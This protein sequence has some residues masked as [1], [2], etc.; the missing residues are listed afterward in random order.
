MSDGGESMSDEVSRRRQAEITALVFAMAFPSVLTWVYFVILAGQPAG[1]QQGTYSIGKAIQFG[2]P[3]AWALAFERW[4]PARTKKLSAGLLFG[5][6][7]GVLIAGT[8]LALFHGWLKPAGLF[9]GP[10]DAVREKVASLGIT[11]PSQFVGL[12][13]FYAVCHSLLEE[14]YWRWF[15]F[16]RLSRLMPLAAAILISSMG[17]MAHHVILLGMYFGYDSMLTWIFS[18]SVAV[19]GAVWAWLYQ[20]SGSLL[21]PWLSHCLVDAAIFL[22]GFELVQG[23]WAGK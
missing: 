6:V 18:I 22:I 20:R 14:Y 19:G 8:T 21:G 4:R 11:T 3:L 17:F 10:G 9:D 13:I 2:F 7:F 16:A 12:S 5:F 23:L 1:L 15:V